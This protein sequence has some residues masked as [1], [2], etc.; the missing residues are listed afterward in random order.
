MADATNPSQ[1]RVAGP[2]PAPIP[3]LFA[4]QQIKAAPNAAGAPNILC[5]TNLRFLP[6]SRQTATRTSAVATN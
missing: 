3:Y 2:R 1:L 5:D 6:H 4:D